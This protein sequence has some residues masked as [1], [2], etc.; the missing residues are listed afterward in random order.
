M[1][2]EAELELASADLAPRAEIKPTMS[3]GSVSARSGRQTNTLAS[4]RQKVLYDWGKIL[5]AKDDIFKRP[6]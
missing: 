2:E 5:A 6:G 1:S 4:L 3:A